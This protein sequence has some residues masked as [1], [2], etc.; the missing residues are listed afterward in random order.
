M[1]TL[2]FTA[3]SRRGPS[4]VS[5]NGS[6]NRGILSWHGSVVLQ[7]LNLGLKCEGP[8]NR[9]VRLATYLARER[10]LRKTSRKRLALVSR[11]NSLS[12]LSLPRLPYSTASSV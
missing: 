6:L 11:F 3:M 2:G 5:R 12:H 7:G 9:L 1:G 4:Y 10:R 8:W